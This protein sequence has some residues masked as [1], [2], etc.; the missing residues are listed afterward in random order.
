MVEDFSIEISNFNRN[1]YQVHRT[2]K[3]MFNIGLNEEEN[4]RVYCIYLELRVLSV[5]PLNAV[6]RSEYMSA[7]V[8]FIKK[9]A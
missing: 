2:F 7:L 4:I 1:N 8:S 6:D 3:K 5:L 9:F